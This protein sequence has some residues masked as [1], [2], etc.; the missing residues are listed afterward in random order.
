MYQRDLPLKAR[1]HYQL[2]FKGYSRSGC[3]LQVFLHKHGAPYTSYGL[4]SWYCDLTSEWRTFMCEFTSENI[5]DSVNDGRLRFWFAP[6]A[7]AGDEYFIDDVE[8]VETGPHA[9]INGDFEWENSGWDFFTDGTG[10]FEVEL[11]PGGGNNHAGHVK[12]ESVGSNTQLYQSHIDLEAGEEYRLSFRAFSQMSGL[13]QSTG[14]IGVYI[15]KHGAP[16]G[17]Y[18]LDWDAQPLRPGWNTYAKDFV[19][20]GFDGRV[21]DGRLR[22]WFSPFAKA[23]AEYFIDDVTLER[24]DGQR[25]QHVLS[26][27]VSSEGE[28]PNGPSLLQNYPNPF[29]PSTTIRYSVP[30]RSHVTLT[31][32]NMLGQRLAELANG[33]VEAGYHDVTFDGSSLPSGV[34]FYRLQVG[35]YMEAKRLLV[36]R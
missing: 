4:S 16:Y 1:T 22:F 29:N 18:G 31:V 15:H 28:K 7:A 6:F 21:E 19:A 8:L 12:I 9:L 36:L 35:T 24:V 3:D 2:S 27:M 33:E 23:G 20:Q 14:T 25:C 30:V 34:Y 26:G 11:P 17:N 10:S 32:Y 13:P 5:A